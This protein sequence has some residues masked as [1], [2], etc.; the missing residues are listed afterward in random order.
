MDCHSDSYK[1]TFVPT[2]AVLIV[3]FQS[4]PLSYI[5]LLYSVR[6]RLNP[7]MGNP[8]LAMETRELDETLHAYR[9]LFSD[10]KLNRWYFE[11]VDLYRRIFFIGVLPLIS[12]DPGTKAYLGSGLALLSAICEL[13]APTATSSNVY[14]C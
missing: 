10:Y 4:L 7:K 6:E 12:E 5:A 13:S 9:F 1:K 2:V 11:I 8:T 3:I 14:P